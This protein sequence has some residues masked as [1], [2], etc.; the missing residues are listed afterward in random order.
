MHFGHNNPHHSY[1]LLGSTISASDCVKDI[2]VH[3]NDKCSAS[4]HVEH[5]TKKANSILA[6]LRRTTI[7]RSM[8]MVTRLYKTYVRPLVESSVQAWNPWLQRDVQRIEKV[9]RRAT[10]LVS[11]IGSKP[12]EERLKICNLTT[13]ERRRNRGDLLECYKIMNGFGDVE[14]RELFSLAS[15]RHNLNTR[16]ATDGLL[17]PQQTH[18]DIRKYFF[19][20]RVINAWNE[21]PLEIRHASSTNAFKNMYDHYTTDTTS[22]IE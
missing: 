17:V 19:F 5:I 1:S 6:Q 4:T 8:D 15:D 14:L 18:L 7:S 13:L 10:K 3:I 16:S 20:N 9:Q 11:G 21:L 2:G 22:D 12:Y